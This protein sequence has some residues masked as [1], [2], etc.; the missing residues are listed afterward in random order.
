M[1]ITDVRAIITAP[2]GVNLVVVKVETSEPGLYGLGC[3]TFAWRA[4]A[5][6]AVVDDYLKPFLVGRNPEN[7]EDIW[8]SVNSSAYWRNGPVLNNALSGVDMALWDIKGKS[9]GKPVYDLL[10]GE[11]RGGVPVYL[12]AGGESPEQVVEA[13]QK[14]L[15]LG[16][17]HVRCQTSGYGGTTRDGGGLGN[18]FPGHYFDPEEYLQSVPHLFEHLRR[19]MGDGVELLHDV[20]ERL[21]GIQAVRLAKLLEPYHLFFLEDV[22]PPE[23]PEWFRLVR[24]QCA[25]PL[26]M[27]ELFNHPL[28][29]R[30]LIT[31]HLIDYIRVHVSQ[32]GGITPARK[33][34]NLCETHGVKTAWHGPP[35]CSP[36]GHA[37]NVHLDI[38]TSN[39]GI[40]EWCEP[41]GPVTEVFEGCL[42]LGKDGMVHPSAAP[43]LGIDINEAEAARYPHMHVTC[44]WMHARLPDGTAVQP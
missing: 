44:G 28:E 19:V 40:Q 38:S 32:I 9:A 35:D 24:K 10:G 8:Q 27:G 34:A 18:E 14:C 30:P 4:T 6:K 7:V 5:V 37:A 17:R 41:R 2:A 21:S 3:A 43:G 31:E 26:A 22:L 11:C 16:V 13:V 29:W 1:K 12:H 36:V 23:Q 42:Q 15:E 39:F 20:H 25:T 33:L